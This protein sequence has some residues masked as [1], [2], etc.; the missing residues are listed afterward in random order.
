VF[1]DNAARMEEMHGERAA[2]EARAAEERRTALLDMAD[3]LEAGVASVV[4]SVETGCADLRSTSDA[5]GTLAD[6]ADGQ[7]RTA[8]Q[9]SQEASVNVQTVASATEE[10][11]GSIG[12]IS[13]QVA[14]SAD[15]ARRAVAGVDGTNERV[16]A[17]TGA[18]EKIGQIVQ[19]INAIAE[20]TNLLAL[21]ATIEA[22]R[23][24]EAG[25]GFAVVASEVKNLANQTARATEDIAG[26][27]QAMQGATGDTAAAIAEIGGVIRQID[28]IAA[29]IAAA[30]E[31][32]GSATQEIARNVEQAA[33]GTRTVAV[34]IAG[35]SKASEETG[36]AAGQVH[37][38]A[39]R[40]GQESERLRQEIDGFLAQVRA[41]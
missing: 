22:A 1:K 30:V 39:G 20:Q 40:L 8:A 36:Q 35:V 41:G 13:Q 14:H 34:N 10:L 29:A 12:E 7:A 24:G 27:V 16:Q 15:I 9:G 33:Q 23:A 28:E 38:I 19:L 3:R 18:A 6:K 31:E 32:Q 4:E 11:T 25:K 2:A 5:L 26:Q 37:A 17:L 21:N